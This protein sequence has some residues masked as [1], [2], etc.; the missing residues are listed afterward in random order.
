MKP[1]ETKES[2]RKRLFLA[3]L[4]KGQR[5]PQFG[6]RICPT[7]KGQGAVCI[8]RLESGRHT[9]AFE[10]CEQCQGETIVQAIDL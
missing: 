8:E 5:E 1:S 9:A 10:L 2:I 6:Y 4:R 7:C 3:A